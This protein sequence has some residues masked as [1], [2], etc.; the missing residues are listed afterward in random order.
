M[1]LKLCGCVSIIVVGAML[2]CK[3][4]EKS[5]KRVRTLLSMEWL[6]KKAEAEL[7]YNRTP[8]KELLQSLSAEPS[9]CELSFLPKVSER[10][11]AGEPFPVVWAD[12]ISSHQT[13][14]QWTLEDAHT[15]LSFGEI[16]GSTDLCGQM[17]EFSFLQSE[18]S[19]RLE[20]AKEHS[21]T[22]GHMYR[23]LGLFAGIGIALLLL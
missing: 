17:E 20:L 7:R 21:L 9:L 19:S 22:T 15:V 10:V 13:K 5:A 2:G 12:E 8:T 23:S 1:L 18:L 6:L 16:L 4:A 11:S 14:M 3:A